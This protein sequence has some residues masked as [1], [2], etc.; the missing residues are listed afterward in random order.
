MLSSNIINSCFEELTI[1]KNCKNPYQSENKNEFLEQINNITFY[2]P[3]P[4]EKIMGYTYKSLGTIFI[5]NNLPK[6][7]N[8]KTESAIIKKICDLSNKKVTELHEKAFHYMHVILYGNS[9]TDNVTTP[10]S[11]FI[12]Y[13]PSDDYKN[14][15]DKYYDFGDRGESL[16][17]G[18]KIIFLFL[19]SSLFILDNE[20]WKIDNIEEFNNKFIELNK[21]IEGNYC[22]NDEKNELTKIY[23][24]DFLLKKSEKINIIKLNQINCK[25]NFRISNNF[26]E[27][28]NNE[29]E[30]EEEE[31]NDDFIIVDR[32]NLLD[33][34]YGIFKYC[35]EKQ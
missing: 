7:N 24:E 8:I 14:I 17:F 19:K 18:D 29:E 2:F 31:E 16:L 25:V 1:R 35:F 10:H 22:L 23:I 12:N 30:E 34:N 15:Y 20:N 6:R 21:F 32:V 5:N 3:F 28:N 33:Y 26:L 13:I 4:H 27:L 11:S 9:I